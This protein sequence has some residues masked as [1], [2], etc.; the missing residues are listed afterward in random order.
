V[1]QFYKK[2]TVK[3]RLWCQFL[4]VK[5]LGLLSKAA[6]I[7]EFH[8]RRGSQSLTSMPRE[9]VKTLRKVQESTKNK[10]VKLGEEFK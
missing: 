4:I 7:T 2:Q 1:F 5:E 6:A 8:W 3:V 9:D 10:T